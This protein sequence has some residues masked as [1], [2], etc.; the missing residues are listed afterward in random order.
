[1]STVTPIRGLVLPEGSDA[2]SRAQLVAAFTVLDDTVS[3]ADARLSNQRTPTDASVTYAKLAAGL[4][5]TSSSTLA[6]GNDSRITGAAQKASNLSDLASAATARTN[7]G[8]GGAAVL[9]VGT[10][11]GTVAAGD[12]ARFSG[13][14]TSVDPLIFTEI[15]VPSSPA[16]DKVSTY[17]FDD[18]GK[19]QVAAK[20]S[21]GFIRRHGRDNLFIARNDTGVTI[22]KGTAVYISGSPYTTG[23]AWPQIDKARA[24]STTTMGCVGLAAEAIPSGSFG[25]VMRRG[26]LDNLDTSAYAASQSALYVSTATAGALVQSLPDTYAQY[27]GYCLVSN[28]ST[29]SLL[30]DVQPGYSLF[31]AKIVDTKGD[32]LGATADNTL[33]KLAVGTNGQVLTADSTTTTGLKWATVSGGGSG[34]ML[35]ANNL[36]DLVSAST[37]RTNLGLGGAATLA[38]GTT[39]GTVAAGDDSRI[40]GSVQKSLVTTK[41]DL[42]VATA[43]ATPARLGVGANGQVL[44]ADSTQTTGVKW[45]TVSGGGGGDMLAANNLSDLVSV[46]TART[47]L[48]LGG[49]A[50]L[51]VGTIASTVAAGDDSRITGAAQKASNLSDL[52]NVATART[53]LGLGG[54]ATLAVGTTTGTVAAGDDSRITG[55]VQK[56]LVTTKGDIIAAT[57]SSTPARVGVGTDGQVLTA[58]A[59]SAA[60]VKWA[61]AAGGGSVDPITFTEIAAPSSPASDKASM[62]V[63]DDAGKTVLGFKT[64]D[65]FITRH[66]Q[67]QLFIVRNASG[68]TIVK[69]AAV[70]WSGTYTTGG[71]WPKVLLARANSTTTLPCIGL[72][73]EDIANN[74]FGFVMRRGQLN[75]VDTSAFSAV[76]TTPLYVST[77]TAGALAQSLPNAFSQQVGYC[78]FSDVTTGKLLVDLQPGYDLFTGKVV[79]T[80]GDLLVASADNTVSALAVGT[81]GKV[82]TADSA[83]FTGLSWA[84]LDDTTKIAK[85]LVTTKG[86]I[87]AATAAS[88][89]ARLGVGTD[90]QVLT[91]DAASTPGVKWAT[92]TATDA[93]KIANALVDAKGDIITATA[94]D[95]P[96]RKAVSAADGT[97]LKADSSQADGLAWVTPIDNP[98]IRTGAFRETCPRPATASVNPL[99]LGDITAVAIYLYKGEVVT[100]IEFIACATALASPTHQFF[101]LR[102]SSYALLA[103]TPDD[104]TTAWAA[105]TAKKLN[106]S[107]PFTITTS[108]VYYLCCVV[109][110]TTAPTLYGQTLA[111]AAFSAITPVLAFKD[112]V[113]TGIT[114][115]ASSPATA[116]PGQVSQFMWAAVY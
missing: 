56:S 101:E 42:V 76:S 54:A 84:T 19:T 52:A 41:G 22:A 64:S 63:F 36:S 24:N 99:T 4:V 103:Q 82:L 9:A 98:L 33:G 5:G 116:T 65:G 53:N 57:A 60:G 70:Y 14:G 40:T 45:A 96:S 51:A 104:T 108:G 34:D 47:N 77:S 59:A 49:A 72:A 86:D 30:V 31:T 105:Q 44:T 80:K 74:S 16:A 7:L 91:A 90:G 100:S 1:M 88:T 69:G 21:D 18:A 2:P 62:Y 35:A 97:S 111:S 61:A 15:A 37:A 55:S 50:T 23:G 83:Q 110:G 38:V 17:A 112:V 12:D 92:A 27:V 10:T 13:G 115:P 43:S 66:G 67:D 73:A 81:N 95:T 3:T 113:H 48:G 106:L 89:P 25:L 79:D 46:A 8:L 29:G 11:A 32:I 71:D 102:D 109:A 28:A 58:D 114:T 26:Q 39:A 6:A 78:L 68:S 85:S 107:A 87:I 93:T 20:T 75:N 94:N